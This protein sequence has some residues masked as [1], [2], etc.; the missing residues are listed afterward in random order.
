MKKTFSIFAILAIA[1][2]TV[3][4]SCSDDDDI[5]PKIDITGEWY[6]A[7]KWTGTSNIYSYNGWYSTEGD[8]TLKFNA[9]KTMSVT[10]ES[11]YITPYARVSIDEFNECYKYEI[12]DKNNDDGSITFGLPM[13]YRISNREKHYWW[14][15]TLKSDNTIEIHMSGAYQEAY[16]LKRK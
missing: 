5:I 9:D 12:Y 6:V 3:F 1:T 14:Y 4:T 16:L 11:V 10:G 13:Y 8:L 7:G 15:A 2:I